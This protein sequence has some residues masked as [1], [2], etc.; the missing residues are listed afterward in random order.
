MKRRTFVQR[1]AAT[2]IVLP[3]T[4]GFPRLRAFAKSPGPSQFARISGAAN[5]NVLVLIRL[6]G[7][8]DGL[9]TVVPYTS[10]DYY[11]ARKQGSAD[12]LS[13]AADTVVKL[14]GS[15]TLGLHPNLAP[16]AE[17]FTEKKLA[18]VE[19]VGYPNQ[20]LS[21]F[22]STDIWLSASDYN[23]YENAGWYAKYL[24]ELYPDY[25]DVLPK[26][27][28]AIELGTYLST[29]LIG[30]KNN[31]GIAVADLSYIPGLPGSDPVADT[32]AGQEEEYVK[33]IALQANLF[34]NSI[35]EAGKKQTTNKVTY[36]SGNT[37]GTS[38]AAIS[39]LIAA[40]LGTQMY[41]VNVGGYDTH[42]NELA[43]HVTLHTQLAGA[44]SAFQR[45]LEAFGT[46]T[47]VAT[48]TISEFGR[49]VASNG[50]G[51]DH[52]SA[53]PL[54]VLGKGV[55]GGIYGNDPNLTNLEG[56]GNIRMEYDFRQIYAS[57][58]GQWFGAPEDVIQPKALPRHFDQLPLFQTSA[59]SA[60]AASVATAI[61]QVGQNYPNPAVA[62]TVVP[63]F[64]V[65][66]GM[67]ARISLYT[68][69]GRRVLAESVVPGQT[70]V[71]LDTRGLPTGTYIYELTAGDQRRSRTMVVAR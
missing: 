25:P 67:D 68:T 47:K 69:D 60:D 42:T 23:V 20:N 1:L 70:S 18:I 64:G 11:T 4:M 41:I 50:T 10:S 35:I 7:G 19:N 29:T 49:R 2:G 39:R 38:L 51:T 9:N 22:R 53:A 30:E 65:K 48:M 61:L 34:A 36:P 44:L 54:F 55:N 14:A 45:D 59:S 52:G 5:N 12:N 13:I 17:F 28:F 58:L 57:V 16:L 24:E 31:M 26:D 6:A 8:N 21:H 62:S 46:D 33:Q 37:L 66:A 15:N 3:M 40:G 43:A 71:T 27:P 56:N 32:H 63:I